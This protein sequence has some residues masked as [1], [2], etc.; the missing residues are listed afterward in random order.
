MVKFEDSLWN[1]AKRMKKKGWP[2]YAISE[3]FKDIGEAIQSDDSIW[4]RCIKKK[5]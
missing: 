1:I 5:R 4:E 3:T 2:R